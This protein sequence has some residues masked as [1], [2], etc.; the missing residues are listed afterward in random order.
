MAEAEREIERLQAEL[1]RRA[2]AMRFQEAL[3]AI[4]EVAS[5]SKATAECLRVSHKRC[6]SMR[7]Y[8]DAHGGTRGSRWRL[9]I[10]GRAPL[11][12]HAPDWPVV[13]EP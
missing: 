1:E 10:A 8:P 11:V 13:N 3:F 4:S 6:T 12:G 2:H 5:S 9:D 7:V